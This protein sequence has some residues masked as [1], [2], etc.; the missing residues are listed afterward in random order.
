MAEVSGGWVQG[1][2][3]L[4]WMDVVKVALRNRGLMVGPFFCAIM[5]KRKERVESLG[6][7]VTD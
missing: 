1:R 3:R 4:F 5:H 7:Y 2:L 6:A